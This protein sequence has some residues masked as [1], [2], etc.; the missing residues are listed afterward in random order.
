MVEN[1]INGYR[2]SPAAGPVDYAALIKEIFADDARYQDLV[3]TSRS[4]YDTELNW[5]MWGKAVRDIVVNHTP[6]SSKS[7]PAGSGIPVE[8]KLRLLSR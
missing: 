7:K 8:Q 1:G 3:Y 5:Q 2:L 4:K 6:A